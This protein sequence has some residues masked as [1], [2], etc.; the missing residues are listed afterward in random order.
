MSSVKEVLFGVIVCGSSYD[1]EVC[2]LV[3]SFSIESSY[4]VEV[5]LCQVLLNVL[6]LDGALLLVYLLYFLRDNINSCY[7]MM[8]RQECCYG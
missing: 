2:I 6:I 7:L 5:F 8:L 4:K 1:Y 3:G